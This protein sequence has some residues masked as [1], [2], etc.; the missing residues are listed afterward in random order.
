MLIFQIISFFGF[1]SI[2]LAL[3]IVKEAVEIAEK[4]AVIFPRKE[5]RYLL[6]LGVSFICVG[7]IG[8]L[9]CRLIY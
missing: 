4:E 6:L 9:I 2:L 7:G 8:G 5:I 3:C 1:F